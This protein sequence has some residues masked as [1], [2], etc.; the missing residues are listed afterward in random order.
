MRG[1]YYWE[2]ITSLNSLSDRTLFFDYSKTRTLCCLQCL[3]ITQCAHYLS[4]ISIYCIS[5]EILVFDTFHSF[6]YVHTQIFDIFLSLLY[7]YLD[8]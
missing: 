6:L 5:I 7:I 1:Y 3:V 2:I 8:I 4:I